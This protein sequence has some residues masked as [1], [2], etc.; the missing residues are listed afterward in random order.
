MLYIS[1]LVFSTLCYGM[2]YFS[3]NLPIN[4]KKSQISVEQR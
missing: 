3:F 1:S 4:T 2:K